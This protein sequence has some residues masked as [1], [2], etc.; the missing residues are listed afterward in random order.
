MDQVSAGRMASI[1]MVRSRTTEVSR[2]LGCASV[3]CGRSEPGVN[4]R[5]GRSGES[6][7]G[8]HSLNTLRS[9]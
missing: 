8:P 9:R 6:R 7:P 2:L 4:P 3:V 1:A 5:R